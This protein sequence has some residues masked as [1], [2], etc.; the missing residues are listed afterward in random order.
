MIKVTLTDLPGV[1]VIEP[2]VHVDERG[3]LFESYNMNS[4]NFQQN[5]PVE[6]LQDNHVFSKQGVLRGMH[7]Q[8]INPQGKLV[9]VADGEI[10]DVAIDVR[11]GSQTFGKYVSLNISA[12]NFKMLYVP[13]GFA[14]GY[15]V[16]SKA[17][18]VL[19]KCTDVYHPE[20]SYGIVWNDPEIGI[21]WP[22]SNPILSKTDK[23][24]PDLKSIENNYL[25]KF[26][27]END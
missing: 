4:F 19:Y 25:P 1:Y 10:F 24:L 16:I 3:Y 26:V 27:L 2:D 17:A 22:I 21:K 14:H 23:N 6:F 12:N 7:Y 5:I 11:T 13:E 9:M 8:L 18:K 20:D 15:Q